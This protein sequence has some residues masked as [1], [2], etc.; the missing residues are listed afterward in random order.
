MT[1]LRKTTAPQGCATGANAQQGG[2]SSDRATA[3]RRRAD[4]RTEGS[5]RVSANR[6]HEQVGHFQ[7][8]VAATQIFL[9]HAN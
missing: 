9:V 3:F 8:N 2:R 4:R 1:L 7:K 6:S 5:N